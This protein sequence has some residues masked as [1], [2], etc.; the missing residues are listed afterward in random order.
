MKNAVTVILQNYFACT[1]A[2]STNRLLTGFRRV[3]I[4]QSTK[5]QTLWGRNV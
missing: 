3:V 2:V 5:I 4:R 1:S